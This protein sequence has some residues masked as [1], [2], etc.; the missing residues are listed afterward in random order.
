[1]ADS[2]MQPISR[3]LRST[4]YGGTNRGAVAFLI[5]VT[6][7]ISLVTVLST[8]TKELTRF[9]STSGVQPPWIQLWR[10]VVDVR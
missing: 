7:L 8:V 9:S 10:G 3:N 2:L 4:S 5:L 1:M 6:N